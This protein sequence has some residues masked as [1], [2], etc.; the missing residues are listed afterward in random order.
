MPLTA[1]KEKEFLAY[2]DNFY[3]IIESYYRGI[4]ILKD[5]EIIIYNDHEKEI[6]IRK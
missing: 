6:K 1:K 3:H 4:Q 2:F 5:K